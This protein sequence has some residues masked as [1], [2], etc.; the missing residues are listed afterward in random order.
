MF[1]DQAAIEHVPHRRKRR[2]EREEARG[3]DSE[4][5][6]RLPAIAKQRPYK[7]LMP[8]AIAFQSS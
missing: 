2:R 6:R 5:D 7:P 4:L 3:H 1:D 8:S